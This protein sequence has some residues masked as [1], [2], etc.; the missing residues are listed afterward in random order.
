MAYKVQCRRDQDILYFE[1]AG[2]ICH[3]IDS[4]AAYVMYRIAESKTEKVLVDFRNAAGRLSPA[5]VF[6]HVLK[7]PPMHHINCALIHQEHNRDFLLLYA[8]LMRHRGHKM[9][10]FASIAE[11]TAWLLRGRESHVGA[12]P[13]WLSILRKLFQSMLDACS[14]HAKA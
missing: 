2:R 4:I 8:K 14:V 1:V 3:H 5:K 10:L 7:Y 11:G 6:T 12:S 9:Q 13:K